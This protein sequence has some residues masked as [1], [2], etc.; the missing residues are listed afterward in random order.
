VQEQEFLRAMMRLT[1]EQGP[2]RAIAEALEVDKSGLP[3]FNPFI[4]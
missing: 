2:M 1:L 3:P 4:K